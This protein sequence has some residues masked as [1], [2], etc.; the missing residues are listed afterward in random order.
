MIRKV[1]IFDFCETMVCFQSADRFVQFI[2]EH[3]NNTFF[4]GLIEFLRKI[5]NKTRLIRLLQAFDMNSYINKRLLLFELRGLTKC[6]IDIMAKEFFEEMIV[7]HFVPEVIS[8]IYEYA[9]QGWEIC[10][11]SG[12]YDVYLKIVQD[13]FS[14][15]HLICTKLRFIDNTFTGLYDGK[16]CIGKEKVHALMK[17]FDNES[18][19]DYE[20]VF[21]TDSLTDL[22]M[23]QLCTR[24]VVVCKNSAPKWALQHGMAVLIC[25]E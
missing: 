8:A 10:I 14:I 23:L 1:A 17:Y 13:Y 16:D 11:L 3:R 25:Q 18:F 24:G 20:S 21:F 15:K 19:N 6:Q 5:L 9:E 7:P 12:G 2:N 22:P 4:V